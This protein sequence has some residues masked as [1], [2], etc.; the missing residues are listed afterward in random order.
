M[1]GGKHNTIVKDNAI[2]GKKE[3]KYL[4]NYIFSIRKI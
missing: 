3:L 4:N 1:V 2:N